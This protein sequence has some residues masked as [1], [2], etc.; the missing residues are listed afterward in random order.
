MDY[1]LYGSWGSH[2][3]IPVDNVESYSPIVVPL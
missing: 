1:A 2:I 3:V